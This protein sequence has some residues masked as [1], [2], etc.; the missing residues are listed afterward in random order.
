LT[1]PNPAISN[2]GPRASVAVVVPIYKPTLDRYE[3]FGLEN[4]VRILS[5]R[6]LCFFAPRGLDLRFYVHNFP[7]AHF[8]FFEEDHFSS[9][10]G[11]NRLM[12]SEAFY[13]AFVP[14]EYL[15]VL[16][17]DAVVF[18]DALDEWMA[19]GI[20]YVGAPWP[21]WEKVVMPK[22]SP[23]LAGQQFVLGVGNGGLSLR[24]RAGAL[25][26]IRECGWVREVLE[27]NEDVLFSLAGQ[28]LQGYVVP[29]IAEAARF[30]LELKPEAMLELSGATPMGFHAWRKFGQRLCPEWFKRFG[31]E[32][33]NPKQP[34]T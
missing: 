22:D 23:R 20:D 25:R 3:F 24:R 16:Q 1:A 14:F 30:S 2:G 21:W 28:L 32:R 13:E 26:A 34:S 10:A 5:G 9:I 33:M 4:S 27:I 8:V 15:L 17:P 11:Y 29:G 12:T 7:T 6:H 19:R 31:F 18:F